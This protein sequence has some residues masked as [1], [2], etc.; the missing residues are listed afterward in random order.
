MSEAQDAIDRL[1]SS[2]AEHGTGQ[3]RITRG[4]V[5]VT[6]NAR[7]LAARA[8]QVVSRSSSAQ[9]IYKGVISSS[10]LGPLGGE[11]RRNDQVFYNGAS[12]AVLWANPTSYAGTLVR[13]DF[14]M[15]G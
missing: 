12:R 4:A 11:L 9:I 3:I 10:G 6:V 14:E 7:C 5:S 8:D 15:A 13:I 1:D 2:L